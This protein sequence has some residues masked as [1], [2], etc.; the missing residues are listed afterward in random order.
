MPEKLVINW[1]QVETMSPEGSFMRRCGMAVLLG[2]GLYIVATTLLP[3]RAHPNEAASA[4]AEYARDDFWV[5]KHFA[6]LSGQLLIGAAL[7]DLM[8]PYII[9]A[10][11]SGDRVDVLTP[12]KANHFDIV[13]PNTVN[14]AAVVDFIVSTTLRADP[15]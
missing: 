4:F 8:Q 1:G 6:Q 13:T 12:P 7:Q 2:L 11:A 3:M 10:R 9:A 14:G 5:L 15:P